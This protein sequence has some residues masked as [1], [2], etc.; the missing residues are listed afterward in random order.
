MEETKVFKD[1]DR[2]A[3]V[4]FDPKKLE[5]LRRE[6]ISNLAIVDH[7]ETRSTA[8][9]YYSP[10]N[11]NME[12][13]KDIQIKN[14]RESYEPWV[15]A[16]ELYISSYNRVL[17]PYLARLLGELLDGDCKAAYSIMGASAGDEYIPIR[18]TIEEYAKLIAEYKAYHDKFPLSSLGYGAEARRAENFIQKYINILLDWEYK[19]KFRPYYKAA[20]EMISIRKLEVDEVVE[21]KPATLRRN[22]K[23][24]NNKRIN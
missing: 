1:V 6:I 18:E 10:Q 17:I 24:T 21:E 13:R 23:G 2:G 9:S 3:A 20:K 22:K 8:P 14:F 11:A 19:N 5:S 12:N 15:D 4:E 16:W 7:F